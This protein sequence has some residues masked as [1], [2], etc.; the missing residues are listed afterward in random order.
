MSTPES[1]LEQMLVEKLRSLKYEVRDD[2]RDRASLEKNFR[3]K[4]QT[5]NHVRLEDGEFDRLL[6]EIVT[7]DVCTAAHTLRNSF[8]LDD[9]APL[10]YTLANIDD[11]CKNSYEVVSQLRIDAD[12]SHHRYDVL[13]LI[14]GGPVCQIE[15]TTPGIK[16]L[17]DH[18]A[19]RRVQK[20]S[21]QRLHAQTIYA[22]GYNTFICLDRRSVRVTAD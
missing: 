15:L 14:N 2:I 11:R 7:P 22:N 8:A 1:Q 20:R 16:S 21:R 13:P 17:P 19:D 12:S 5:L 9:G 18:R 4:F 3:Q 6:G 10:K